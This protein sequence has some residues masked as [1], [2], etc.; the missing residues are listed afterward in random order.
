MVNIKSSKIKW[1][2][3][4]KKDYNLEEGQIVNAY[5]NKQTKSYRTLGKTSTGGQCC[6]NWTVKEGN[7][8]IVKVN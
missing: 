5:W 4:L 8:E 1:L 3:I 6:G 7:Y 2:K